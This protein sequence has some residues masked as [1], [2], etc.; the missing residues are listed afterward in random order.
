MESE[1]E[2][3][4]MTLAAHLG[5]GNWGCQLTQFFSIQAH[6]LPGTSS[7]RPGLLDT[8]QAGNTHQWASRE[9]GSED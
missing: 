5:F 6:H 2:Y 9:A 7:E 4:G 3:R 8:G 1:G